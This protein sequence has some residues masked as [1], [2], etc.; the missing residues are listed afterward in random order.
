MKIKEKIE[1]EFIKAGLLSLYFAL[2]FCAL[3]FLAAT[4]FQHDQLKLA[5]FGFALIKAALCAKFMLLTQAVYPFHYDRSRGL[6][7]TLFLK[8]ILYLF[9]I[10][11][12]SYLESGI[13]SQVHGTS[14]VAGIL[15]FGHGDPL[16]I[17]ALSFVYWLIIWPYLVFCGISVSLGKISTRELLF[18][19]RS[20]S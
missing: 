3:A 7:G 2:W 5:V 9:S 6:F 19:V 8:S 10:L 17:L 15:N 12:L 1:E 14:F 20:N 13:D 11:V 18:G 16:N 4:S